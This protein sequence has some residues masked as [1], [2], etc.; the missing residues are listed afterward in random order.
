M[1]SV[2]DMAVKSAELVKLVEEHFGD[3]FDD[4]DKKA[5][6]EVAAKVYEA[7][8]GRDALVAMMNLTF[9]KAGRT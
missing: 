5:L 8:T 7:K 6:L 4:A 1:A 3:T 9:Q 2:L